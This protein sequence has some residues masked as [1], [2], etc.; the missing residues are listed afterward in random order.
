[1]ACATICG[2]CVTG[3]VFVVAGALGA[4][5]AVGIAWPWL[6]MR[7]VSCELSFA[8]HRVREG[9][10]VQAVLRVQN[11]FAFPIWGLVL[12][13]GL[14]VPDGDSGRIGL[15]R[16]PGWTSSGVSLEFIPQQRCGYPLAP[17]E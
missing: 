6:S 7:G 9:E 17:P 16:V 3:H 11:R 14:T 13:R 8:Q 2:F 5:L 1:M 4:V 12:E 15:A 10:A